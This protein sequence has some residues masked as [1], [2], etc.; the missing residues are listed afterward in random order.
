MILPIQKKSSISFTISKKLWNQMNLMIQMGKFSSISDIVSTSITF[1]LGELS[2]ERKNSNFDYSTT[3]GNIPA[4]NSERKKISVALNGYLYTE[5]ENLAKMTQ[6]NKSFIVRMALF[7]FF[8]DYNNTEKIKSQ[9]VVP[10][11]KLAVSKEKLV[12][13]KNELEEIVQEMVNKIL[14]KNK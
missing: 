9:M 13:S 2:A 5:L 14:K 6:K 4:D 1:V 8:E 7:R 3:V 11:E 10:K 12:V